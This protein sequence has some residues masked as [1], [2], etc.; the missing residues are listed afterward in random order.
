MTVDGRIDIN[1]TLH[2]ETNVMAVMKQMSINALVVGLTA[3]KVGLN[4]TVLISQLASSWYAKFN[5]FNGNLMD[6]EQVQLS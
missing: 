2:A 4:P 1:A 3:A 5:G 6:G